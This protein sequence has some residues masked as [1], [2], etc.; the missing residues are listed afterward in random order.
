MAEDESY[1]LFID[2]IDSKNKSSHD[3]FLKAKLIDISAGK[4]WTV[5]VNNED[6]KRM[7]ILV[8]DELNLS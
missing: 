1:P 7:G 5:I 4:S 3:F 6:A 8:G 2:K